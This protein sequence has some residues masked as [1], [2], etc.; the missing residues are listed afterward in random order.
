M[1]THRF[2]PRTLI[3]LAA[4]ASLTAITACTSMPAANSRLDEARTEYRAAQ[5]EPQTRDLAAAELKQASDALMK[6]DDAWTRHAA[7]TDVDHLA[8]LAKTRV[9]IARET[10]RQKAAEQA[11]ASADAAR[12]KARLEARTNEADAAQRNADNAQREADAAQRQAAASERQATAS[13]VQAAASQR[14]NDDAQ[15][16]ARQLEQQ[17]AALDAKKTERGMVVTI[18]NLQFDTNK[19]QLKPEGMRS[20]EKLVGFLKQYPQRK[21]LVE[22]FTDS[23][24][25]AGLNQTLSGQR[26]DA[27]RTAL[28]QMGVGS[29]RIAAHGYGEAFPVAGNESADGRQSNRRVEVVLSGDDGAITPR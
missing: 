14:A 22:G 2:L 5:N 6:A 7:A 27:V 3:A 21:A 29:E 11:V 28:V 13:Q 19:S 12:G 1:N 25:S 4:L 9:A 24:G 16:R 26:A 18:G 23:T 8:Y 10:G 17:L 20:V 15:A